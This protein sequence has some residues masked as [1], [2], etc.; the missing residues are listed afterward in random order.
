[1]HSSSQ[2]LAVT[3]VAN[4]VSGRKVRR[5]LI[6]GASVLALS[7]GACAERPKTTA[8]AALGGA[9]GGLAAAAFGASPA[10]IA[11]GV[12]L[13]ALAG[14]ALG[15][16]LDNADREYAAQA[17]QNA[18]ESAKTGQTVAW[19]NP[20]S[21]HSGTYTPQPAYQNT[22]G[23]YCRE[24]QQTVTVDGQTQTAYGVACR[25]PDGTWKIQDNS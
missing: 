19:A 9:G 7:L 15:N 5:M 18:M 6:V 17:Q 14:G 23:Q 12:L 20:D 4:P 3:P 1:M 13:G 2:A 10:G 25:Q 21:G 24:F 11:A 22:Q 8:G 16:M